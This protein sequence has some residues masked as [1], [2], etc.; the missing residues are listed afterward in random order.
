MSNKNKR[1]GSIISFILKIAL[2]I[3]AIGAFLNRDPVWFI[4]ILFALFL[5]CI[6]SILA[7]D[8]NVRLPL[9]F[10]LTM[11][12]AIFIHIIGDYFDWYESVP[13]FD[14]LTHF[15]SSAIVSLIGVTTLYILVFHFWKARVPALAFGFFTV[16][17]SMAM[18]V[19]WEFME[20]GFDYLIDTE[21]QKSLN[22]TMWDF[23]FD[24]SAGVVMGV[25]AAVKLKYDERTKFT[26]EI[27][28]GDI[29]GS[30]GYQRWQ[31]LTDKNR[32][33]MEKIQVSFKDPIIL[34]SLFDYIVRESKNISKAEE[35][36]WKS[37]KQ[38]IRGEK[39]KNEK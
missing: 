28:I 1:I 37:L 8:Y 23:V 10:D 20:W 9:I 35:E 3:L 39:A 36:F 16:I 33:L 13:N 31:L 12:I 19:T 5:T 11:T 34:D 14:H 24:T 17:F 18:G 4:G 7:R 30:S 29:K 2:L 27:V 21:L 22:D 38:K 15:L 25:F 26:E 6:P 32:D